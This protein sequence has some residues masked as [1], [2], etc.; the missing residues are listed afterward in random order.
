MRNAALLPMSLLAAVAL[1][2]GQEDPSPEP[3]P[4]SE[5]TYPWKLPAGFPRPKVPADNPMS[6][7]KVELGRRLFYD[8]RLSGNG[9]YSCGSCHEQKRAFTDGLG[10]ALGSTGEI[11]PRGSMSLANVGYAA[12]LTWANPLV[13]SLEKQA[14]TPMFGENPVELGL[15]GQEEELFAR[16]R[17]E[18]IY[19]DLFPRAFPEVQ[20]AINL[21]TITKAIAAF[22]RTMISGNSP[23]DRHLAG[24]KGAMSASALRGK[25][26]FFSEQLECFHCHGGF[27]LADS[28]THDGKTIDEVTF[29][30]TGLYNI[31]GKGGYPAPN[32]GVLEVSNQPGDMG[33]FKAPTLRNIAVTAPYMHDGSIATLSEVIDHYAAGGRTI[34]SGPNAGDGSK[35]PY[36]SEFVTGF[37]LTPQEKLD[38]IAF[39]ES[40]TDSDFLTDPALSDPWLAAP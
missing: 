4:S 24:D 5:D 26:L 37:L 29:H 18:P 20:G 8:R 9:T 27:L 2:C 28:V 22:E 17:A 3:S 40:L 15:A 1:A 36:K 16:L 10:G 25:D 33:R 30:N 21:D 38:L 34:P 32:R 7:A 14:L 13:T 12:T 11:H 39:L 19:Q 6:V 31:D 35:N 23:Y